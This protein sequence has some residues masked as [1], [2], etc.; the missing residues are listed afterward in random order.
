MDQFLEKEINRRRLHFTKEGRNVQQR[1]F[2][3]TQ[4]EYDTQFEAD[5][6]EIYR[7]EY[8]QPEQEYAKTHRQMIARLQEED[9]RIR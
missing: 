7:L 3:K 4:W 8:T 9:R 1:S 2:F 5:E 6:I